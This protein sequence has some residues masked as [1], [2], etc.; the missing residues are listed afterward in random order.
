M[1]PERPTIATWS[2][3]SKSPDVANS[4]AM[5]GPGP[6]S[7]FAWGALGYTV[8]VILFGAV[9]RITGSG[10]GC[11]QHWPTCQGEVAHLPQSTETLIELTHRVTSGLSLV[12]VV[13]LAVAAF[14]RFPPRHLVRRAVAYSVVFMLTEA[15][16]GAGLVLLELVGKNDSMTRAVVMSA[17]LVN[18]S[19]LT[20]AMA[21]TAWASGALPAGF[22]LRG[23]AWLLLA[24]LLGVLAV[25]TTGAVTALGDTLYPVERG[26]DLGSRLGGIHFLERGRILHP[27]VAVVVSGFLLWLAPAA[28]G[29]RPRGDVQRWSRAVVGLVLVQV[30]A[31]VVNVL[32]SAPGW[33]QILHLL[34][35]TLAW[36]ALVLLTAS[37]AATAVAR[38]AA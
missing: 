17:H 11:G 24:G 30:L 3:G 19:L 20:G 25:S 38:P 35:A 1:P 7:R 5:T 34:L 31:G 13:V 32:L 23:F 18:T 10:A 21:V 26:A 12:V 27:I 14:R 36:I 33:M 29:R 16:I 15:L 22:R 37:F 9:V 28:A 2:S 8:L 6:F 4:G